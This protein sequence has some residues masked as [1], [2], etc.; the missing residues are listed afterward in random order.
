MLLITKFKRLGTKAESLSYI[1]VGHIIQTF[2]NKPFV[3][4]CERDRISGASDV[5][6]HFILAPEA[7]EFGT[8]VFPSSHHMS[9]VESLK[10]ILFIFGFKIHELN[11][12]SSNEFT[13]GGRLWI[14]LDKRTTVLEQT[15]TLVIEWK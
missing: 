4:A 12:S 7:G 13:Q 5:F 3:D 6:K 14:I 11:V 10:K 15:L 2:T 9:R 1:H 8:I